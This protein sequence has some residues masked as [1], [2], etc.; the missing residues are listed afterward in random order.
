MS[1]VRLFKL[2]P[3]GRAVGLPGEAVIIER[4][5]IRLH[6]RFKICSKSAVTTPGK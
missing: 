4:L 5:Q 6:F 1:D 2:D 3:S